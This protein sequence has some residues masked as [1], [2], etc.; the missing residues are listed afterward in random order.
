MPLSDESFERLMA[1]P[2]IAVIGTTGRDGSPHQAPVWYIWRDGVLLIPTER[3]SQK[4]RNIERDPRVSI[5]I[6][7]REGPTR[8]ALISGAAD[9]LPADYVPFRRRFY[10]RY[11]GDAA[12]AALDANPVDPAAWVVIRITP[13]KTI[14]FGA[15]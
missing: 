11:H 7:T 14:T 10:E 8:V 2:N 5:C 15:D 6:D 3:R 1:A 4:W 9:E 13:G 12:Q